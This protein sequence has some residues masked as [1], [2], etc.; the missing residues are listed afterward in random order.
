MGTLIRNIFQSV[1]E[2]PHMMKNTNNVRFPHEISAG[3][4]RLGTKLNLT[5][6]W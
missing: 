4:I 1:A 3:K 6:I 5:C 2:T